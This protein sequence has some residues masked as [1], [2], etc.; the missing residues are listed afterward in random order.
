MRI[1]ALPG[2]G[3]RGDWF[4]GILH[5]SVSRELGQ[6]VVE[7]LCRPDEEYKRFAR[8]VGLPVSQSFLD[9][10][11]DY[12]AWPGA[13]EEPCQHATVSLRRVFDIHQYAWLR[14]D[15]T[16][17]SNIRSTLSLGAMQLSSVGEYSAENTP[18]FIRTVVGMRLFHQ[19]RMLTADL[20][21]PKGPSGG[22]ARKS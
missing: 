3:F 21:L 13:I 22:P 11:C 2:G 15:I 18:A 14:S 12:F 8:G 4:I 19:L 9:E 7:K 5:G 20:S 6:E 10:N 16:R 17:Y 1:C